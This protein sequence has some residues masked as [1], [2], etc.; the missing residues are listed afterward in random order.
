MVSDP[1]AFKMPGDSVPTTLGPQAQAYLAQRAALL[2][3]S[4]QTRVGPQALSEFLDPL[5]DMMRP[6][7]AEFRGSTATIAL[8]SG[9]ESKSSFVFVRPV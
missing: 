4:G 1:T 6:L 7:A 9:G 8:P 5:V 3:V 2:A